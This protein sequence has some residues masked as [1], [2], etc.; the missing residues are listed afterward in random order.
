MHARARLFPTTAQRSDA[1]SR[2]AGALLSFARTDLLAGRTIE[3]LHN[4]AA[5]A[6]QLSI[7]AN[8]EASM[9]RMAAEL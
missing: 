8:L 7:A 1:A 6:R 2:T 5:A 3:A 9:L 4:L